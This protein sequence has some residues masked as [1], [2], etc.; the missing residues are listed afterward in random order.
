[1]P[2]YLSRTLLTPV[3]TPLPDLPLATEDMVEL[4]EKY[5]ARKFNEDI[6][7]LD[8]LK[9]SLK[10]SNNAGIEGL[11]ELLKSDMVKGLDGL[12]FETRDEHFGSNY[13]APPKK[14][15]STT[16]FH[17]IRLLQTIRCGS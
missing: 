12:D 17:S 9:G 1:M 3:P 6:I 4:V 5:R 7:G 13:K 14:T 8:S 10:K 15:G 2:R 11:A 16:I